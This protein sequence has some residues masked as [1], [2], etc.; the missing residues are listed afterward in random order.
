MIN[1]INQP[2]TKEENNQQSLNVKFFG[3]MIGIALTML[4]SF[5]WAGLPLVGIG[6]LSLAFGLIISSL[7]SQRKSGE[8]HWGTVILGQFIGICG[9]MLLF[10]SQIL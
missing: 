7:M 6:F 1:Q 9:I 5:I 4:A 10:I 8:T 3:I 2:F